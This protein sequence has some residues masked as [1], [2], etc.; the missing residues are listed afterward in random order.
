MSIKAF[1][2]KLVYFLLLDCKDSLCH[3]DINTLTLAYIFFN[4]FTKSMD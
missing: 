3:L 2:F 4:V 1:I